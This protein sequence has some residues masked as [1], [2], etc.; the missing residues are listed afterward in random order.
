MKNIKR[1]FT[2]LLVTVLVMS[3]M[4]GCGKKKEEEPEVV[5]EPEIQDIVILFTGDVHC[6]IEDDIGYAGL[7]AYK[8]EMEELTPNVL[9]V[10]TGDFVDGDIIGAVSKGMYIIDIMNEVGYD[11]ITLGNHEFGA[12]D[13][14][15]AR[16]EAIDAKI[17]VSNMEYTGSSTG[18]NLLSD[19]TRYEIVEIGG[20]KIGFIGICTP[21]SITKSQPRFFKENGEWVYTFHH[22]T[23]EDFYGY[24]TQ[25]AQEVR[26][27]GADYVIALSHLGDDPAA[28]PWTSVETAENTKGIDV[29]L[30]GHAHSTVPCRVLRNSEGNRVLVSATG[31]KLTNIGQLIINQ[32]G[33]IDIGIISD[34]KEK[35]P[36]VDAFVQ[37][38]KSSFEQEVDKVVATSNTALSIRDENGIRVVRSRENPLANLSA[39][40]FRY[41]GNAD[42]G[43]IN[44]GGVRADLPEGDITYANIIAVHPYGNMLSVVEATGQEILDALEWGAR[45]TAA[46]YS[47]DGNAVGECGGFPQVS[48][49]KYTIDTSIVTPCIS[50]ENGLFAGIEGERRVC[51]VMVLN[52]DTNEYEPLDPEKTYTMASH[53][54]LLKNGGDGFTMFQDNKMVVEDAIADY[55]LLIN[56]ITD[57]LQ[58]DLSAYA[59][60]EGRITIK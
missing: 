14:C 43:L 42:I 18:Y 8:K 2:L 55:E 24:I 23:T 22:E 32:S 26:D 45:A 29:F 36:E 40:A 4:T 13:V 41:A 53:E 34:Y 10:D 3:M 57:V 38:V 12:L 44:G 31:T 47:M 7:A 37:S 56:Y 11:Y 50:D 20:R 54:Y 19:T 28:S 1:M 52:Q 30:D 9:L 48:G 33:L 15:Q 21:E 27:A 51:D 60:P 46:S 6:G 39:D 17:I 59:S 16:T 5:P 25:V 49:L 35:D 58:G